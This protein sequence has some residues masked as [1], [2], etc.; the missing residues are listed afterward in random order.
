MDN[1][2]LTLG[3]TVVLAPYAVSVVLTLVALAWIHQMRKH[4]N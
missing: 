3:N 4:A 1:Q 2:Y